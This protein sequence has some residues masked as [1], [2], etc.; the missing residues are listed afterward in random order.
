MENN[1][2]VIVRIAR[3]LA[4]SG[5]AAGVAGAAAGRILSPRSESRST[6]LRV[7]TVKGAQHARNRLRDVD[8]ADTR[9]ALRGAMSSVSDASGLDTERWSMTRFKRKD[10][11]EL[12]ERL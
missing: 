9:N 2:S 11:N 4:I 6:A 8:L 1:E 12:A 3:V 5:V 7:R 10:A